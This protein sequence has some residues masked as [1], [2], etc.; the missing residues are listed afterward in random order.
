[1]CHCRICGGCNEWGPLVLWQNFEIWCKIRG[2]S[3][4]FSC[5][6]SL[7]GAVCALV[8]HV[9]Q[10]MSRFTGS[11]FHWL[12]VCGEDR[13]CWAMLAQTDN[14]SLIQQ[15]GIKKALAFFSWLNRQWREMVTQSEKVNRGRE[16]SAP[17]GFA[18]PEPISGRCGW[19]E[20]EWRRACFSFHPTSFHPTYHQFSPP[21]QKSDSGQTHASAG[22][23]LSA[24]RRFSTTAN[25]S[26][27]KSLTK[28]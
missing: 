14:S 12:C 25:D 28:H 2:S 4:L 17:R 21:T 20:E 8:T 18:T 3:R 9:L 10:N 16:H 1:M 7:L 5:L 26:A 13:L 27:L 24:P 6:N 11:H 23:V 19:G 22:A 15:H